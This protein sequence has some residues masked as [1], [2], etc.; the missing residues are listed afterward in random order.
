[1]IQSLDN[2]I[3]F[4]LESQALDCHLDTK[5]NNDE[6]TFNSN[7]SIFQGSPIR[8][9]GP[10]LARPTCRGGIRCELNFPRRHQQSG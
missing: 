3:Q 7:Q 1:M 10:I 5:N 9:A 2:P 6:K 8:I 4:K